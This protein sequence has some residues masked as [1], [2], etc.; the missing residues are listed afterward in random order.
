[1]PS[2]TPITDS[3][4]MLTDDKHSAAFLAVLQWGSFERAAQALH[5]SPS[6]VSQRIRTLEAR[7]GCMLVTRGHPCVATQ[8]GRKLLPFLR[9]AEW[10]AQEMSATFDETGKPLLLALAAHYD[11]LDTWASTSGKS[12]RMRATLLP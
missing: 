7:L 5:L 3:D 6:A 8:D 11:A 10:L 1:M 4:A 9:H 12:A 2:V